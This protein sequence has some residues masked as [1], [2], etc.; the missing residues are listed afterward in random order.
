MHH[1]MNI[2]DFKFISIKL[3]VIYITTP[4]LSPT[5]DQRFILKI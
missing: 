3:F 5:I 2:D 4:G 1:H